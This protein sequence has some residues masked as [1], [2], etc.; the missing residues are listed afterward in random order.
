MSR[1]YLLVIFSAASL[2]GLGLILYAIMAFPRA[3]LKVAGEEGAALDFSESGEQ[4]G[5]LLDLD[6]GH[7]G[8][9][10]REKEPFDPGKHKPEPL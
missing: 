10:H 3:N 5:E 2:V 9:K 1:F 7:E 6:T 4:A 8:L